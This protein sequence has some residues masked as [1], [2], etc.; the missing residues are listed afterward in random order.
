MAVL[1]AKDFNKGSNVTAD[2][3]LSGRVA[4]VTVNAGGGAPGSGS[5]IRIRGGSS[6]FGSNDPL[7]VIDGL[8]I[9]NNSDKN[10]GSTS[11][12]ASI[13][14][15]TIESVSYTHLDVYKRQN[16]AINTSI[17]KHFHIDNF[18]VK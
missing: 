10:F 3:L 13:N 6:L 8:P 18:F 9:E 1:A 17:S 15:S 2:N 16:K 14:P 11:I 5:T 7:I 4:G 12:L